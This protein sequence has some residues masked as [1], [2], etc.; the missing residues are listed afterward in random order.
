MR[1][2]IEKLIRED[3]RPELGLFDR[4]F[5]NVACIDELLRLR[6]S[7]IMWA[8]KNKRIQKHILKVHNKKRKTASVIEMRDKNKKAVKFTLLVVKK[9][10]NA[11]KTDDIVDQYVAF[12]TNMK[13]TS[14]S[15]LI[16]TIPETYCRRQIIETRHSDKKHDFKDN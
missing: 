7:F 4:G 5:Y 9:K 15:K 3:A 8:I 6:L 14:K 2:I 16:K 10:N 12:A 11:K 1:K 13:I